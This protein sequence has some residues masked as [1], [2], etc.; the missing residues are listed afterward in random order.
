MAELKHIVVDATCYSVSSIVAR[1]C[2]IAL[3]PLYT[4][5]MPVQSG[6]YGILSNFYAWGALL[7]VV[8]GCGMETTFLRFVNKSHLQPTRVF[9]TAMMVIVGLCLL[10]YGAVFVWDQPIAQAIGI[11]NHYVELRLMALNIVLDTFLILPFCRLRYR[12]KSSRY[13]WL[14]IVQGLLPVVLTAY[15]LK[16]CPWLQEHYPDGALWDFY[17]PGRAL[18]YTLGCNVVAS[19]LMLMVLVDEWRPFGPFVTTSGRVEVGSYRPQL[20]VAREM[21]LYALPV[22]GIGVIN[23][24]NQSMDRILFPILRPGE[25][26]ML[27]LSIY[28]AC[29]RIAMI[30]ALAT[31][32]L[33][34]LL[35]PLL[36]QVAASRK[37]VAVSSYIVS[38]YF[39]ILSVGMFLGVM[40]WINELGN[41]LLVDETYREGLPAVPLL[42]MSEIAMGVSFY[43]SFWY[44]LS[45]RPI[46][47]TL[48]S[49]V[50]FVATL[51]LNLLWVPQYGYMGCAWAVFCGSL[52]RALLNLVTS[53]YNSEYRYTTIRNL[54]FIGLGLAIYFV[55]ENIPEVD[56]FWTLASRNICVLVYVFIVVIIE[57]QQI[58]QL[59]VKADRGVSLTPPISNI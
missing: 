24:F 19:L 47:G 11:A 31:Q 23:V 3:V 40:A 48:L 21:L 50:S 35:E 37:G 32:V 41:A 44:K 56:G 25:D 39:I 15:V 38:R 22:L 7:S 49:L 1:L 30:M 57:Q 52:L 59:S 33:R 2:N 36:F 53:H 12:R 29:Y 43:M 20:Q 26:Q 13:M 27:Q 28:G 16:A 8:L 6:E 58:D 14:K 17:L 46:F 51:G 18:G 10:F 34:D 42:M 55:M 5:V 4:S 45:D 9:G 54:F